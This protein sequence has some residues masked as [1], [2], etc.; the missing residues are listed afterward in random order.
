MAISRNSPCVCGS[1]RRFKNCCGMIDAPHWIF[2]PGRV[3]GSLLEPEHRHLIEKEPVCEFDGTNLP[4]GLLIRWLADDY[5]WMTMA[6]GLAKSDS[7]RSGK[8]LTGSGLEVVQQQRISHIV[9]QGEWQARVS[10]LV[11]RAYCEEIEPFFDRRLL[12]F[13]AP[14]VLRYESGGYYRPHADSDRWDQESGGWKRVLDRHLSLLIYLDNGYGGGQLVFPNYDCRLQP[15]AGMLIAFPS[16]H[17]FLHS[18]MPVLGGT[19][20]VVASWS[21]VEGET[22]L[23]PNMPSFALP[24]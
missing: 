17:R 23:D 11:R 1:G 24:R 21:A 13:E 10:E 12:W 3:Q 7:S 9:D 22:L 4:P 5:D 6:A 18:V 20:H 14:V 19:R 8:I 2:G 15:R 16:D